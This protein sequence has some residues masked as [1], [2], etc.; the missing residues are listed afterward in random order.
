MKNITKTLT[1]IVMVG[2]I[3]VSCKKKDDNKDGE[4][5]LFLYLANQQGTLCSL[6]SNGTNYS[7][8]TINANTTEST[9]LFTDITGVKNGFVVTKGLTGLQK[10]VFK[11]LGSVTPKV[12]KGSSC[13]V[14]VNPATATA[15]SSDILGTANGTTTTFTVIT[16]GDY[17]FYLSGSELSGTTVQIQ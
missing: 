11:N 14:T 9:I 15:L 16:A 8:S 7:I 13:S 12:Y 17:F 6:N 3:T 1:L 10:V 4:T 5:A 2:L